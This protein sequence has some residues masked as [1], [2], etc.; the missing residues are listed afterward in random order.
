MIWRKN[1]MKT[2]KQIEVGKQMEVE[3]Q[4]EN[5]MSFWVKS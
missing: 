4:M 1:E 3:K 5:T 2:E